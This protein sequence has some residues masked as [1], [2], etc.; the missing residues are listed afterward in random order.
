MEN[1]KK[2]TEK[3][4]KTLD[5][6]TLSVIATGISTALMLSLRASINSKEP[7]IPK[8]YLEYTKIYQD[9]NNSPGYRAF[10]P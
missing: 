10:M 1:L 7:V 8:I 2:K 6:G 5:R 4:N 3:F 9:F